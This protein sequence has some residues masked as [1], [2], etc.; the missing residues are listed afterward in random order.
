MEMVHFFLLFLT[1]KDIIIAQH[2]PHNTI[3]A[4]STSLSHELGMQYVVSTLL[5]S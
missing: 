5:M 2:R 4:G 3:E 1:S